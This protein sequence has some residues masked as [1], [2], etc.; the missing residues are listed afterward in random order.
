MATITLTNPVYYYAGNVD[1]N[2]WVGFTS[3]H[4]RTVR[5]EFT[6]PSGGATHIS[7]SITKTLYLS[8]S[9]A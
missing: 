8:G 7:L 3:T 9:N 4:Y 1:S 6:A 2:K 5:Y